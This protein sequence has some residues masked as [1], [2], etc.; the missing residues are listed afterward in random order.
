[1]QAIGVG[2]ERDTGHDAGAGNV[3]GSNAGGP[4]LR[5]VESFTNLLGEEARSKAGVTNSGGANASTWD[6]IR[7]FRREL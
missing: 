6:H 5:T 1:V 4:M 7:E 3:V 2:D